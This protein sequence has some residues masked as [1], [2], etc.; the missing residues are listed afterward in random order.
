[1]MKTHVDVVMKKT[2]VILWCFIL[3]NHAMGISNSLEVHIG[4]LSKDVTIFYL[5][6]KMGEALLVICFDE[7]HVIHTLP[8]I[9]D[10]ISVFC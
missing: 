2:R 6:S 9:L 10:V 4:R 7:T 1:M 8:V 5:I 3:E